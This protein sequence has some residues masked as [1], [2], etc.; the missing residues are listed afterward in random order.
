MIK[1]NILS[2]VF[3][4]SPFSLDHSALVSPHQTKECQAKECKLRSV[5]YRVY[6]SGYVTRH[7]MF[8]EYIRKKAKLNEPGRP[9][10]D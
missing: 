1:Q 4:V 10:L 6:A 7:I 2:K 5:R 9:K 8:E 3:S